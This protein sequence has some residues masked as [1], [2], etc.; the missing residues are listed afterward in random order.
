MSKR[1]VAALSDRTTL[2][3]FFLVSEK[4]LQESAAPVNMVLQNT[5]PR[6]EKACPRAGKPG[7]TRDRG[8]TEGRAERA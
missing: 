6:V 3:L 2:L 7:E 4:K 1:L 5:V 8:N